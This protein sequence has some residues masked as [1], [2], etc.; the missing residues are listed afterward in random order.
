MV[1]RSGV[2]MTVVLIGL[3]VCQSAFGD[4]VVNEV[5]ANEPGSSTTLEWVELFNAGQQPVNLA[6]C[7]LYVGGTGVPL[8]GSLDTGKYLIVCRRLYGSGLTPGYESV[9]GNNSGVWGD[10]STEDYAMPVAA[11]FSLANFADT[12]MLIQVPYDTSTLAWSEA[13]R[14]GFSWERVTLST[15]EIRQSIDYSGCT[16]AFVNSVTPVE[17]DLSLNEVTVAHTASG[18]EMGMTVTNMGAGSVIGRRLLICEMNPVMPDSLG[19]ILDSVNIP[20][21]FGGFSTDIVREVS[22][23]G[24]YKYIVVALDADT[25]NR[26]NRKAIVA[27]GAE[28]PPIILS[29]LM[30]NPQSPLTAEWIELHCPLNSS[31]TAQSW[32][33]ADA[34]DTV[35]IS[36]TSIV[37]ASGEFVVL[38]QDTTAFNTYYPNYFGQYIQPP[39][40]PALNNDGDIIRL[41]D[42]YGIVA[43]SFAYANSFDNNY[44]WSRPPDTVI[45]EWGRSVKVGGTPGEVNDV[46]IEP[47]DQQMSLEIEPR[48][49]SPD[50]SGF[51]D[52]ANITISA[53]QAASYTLKIYDREGRPVRVLADHAELLR[54]TYQWDGRTDSGVRLPIGIYICY[55]EATGVQSI[56]KSVVIAR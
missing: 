18:A 40:W 32:K 54:R 1:N 43:D 53:P 11:T 20:T 2:L 23:S 6:L 12:V 37:F 25:R 21:L 46:V 9:W 24:I 13:G 27:P 5:M 35:L 16:P 19:E 10:T 22:F 17:G 14:D 31:F 38:A 44:T 7:Q 33:I 41:I 48:V 30:T 49:F 56:K 34:T 51:E 42:P 3:I 8:T 55:F 28:Y 50:G 29:E 39:Q 45:S 4:V 15:N 26:N 36:S 52:I 47:N